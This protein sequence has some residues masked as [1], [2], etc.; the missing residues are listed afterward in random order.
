MQIT[1]K[2]P[3]FP[4][5]AK[6][7]RPPISKQ[8]LADSIKLFNR[9]LVTGGC[10]F[11]GSNLIRELCSKKLCEDIIVLDNEATSD[12]SSISGHP[13]TFIK[14]DVRNP[15]DIDKAMDGVDAVVHLAADTRVIDSIA[16]PLYNF[17]VN[18]RGTV[19]LLEAMRAHG[20]SR[21]V[22]AST[23][24][25][26]LGEAV[27]PVHEEMV[28][29]PASAY[30]AS[31]AAAE[32]YCSAYSES[33]GLAAASLRFSNVYGPLSLR[34]GSVIAAFIKNALKG[35][36]CV[37]YGDGTQTRDFIFVE[38]LCQG[39]INALKLTS[40]GVFQ[41]GS[42]K[43]TAV[44]EVID[45]LRNVTGFGQRLRVEYRDFRKGEIKH[46]HTDI[47]KASKMLD[48][49]PQTELIDG[50]RATW[51]YFQ[52]IDGSTQRIGVGV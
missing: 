24:G 6:I 29:R 31:K 32:A 13:H 44:N 50:I 16:A 3:A 52:G 19:N 27:P 43:P 34:K 20:V 48:F 8:P 23:G 51:S 7:K 21:L 45:L 28:P 49:E 33:Y 46:N 38:D 35:E 47:S 10:G 26:I 11:I 37:V 2:Y 9:V 18:V 39:I 15:A 41:L 4:T 14:G 17:E 12:R 22:N 25:A 36:T 40:K 30:G 5:G 1:R 42:G